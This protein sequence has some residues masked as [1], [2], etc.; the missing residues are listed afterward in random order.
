M[1]TL[2]KTMKGWLGIALLV[3]SVSTAVSARQ[4]TQTV[5]GTVVDNTTKEPL[6]G[7]SVAL[8]PLAS[9]V[10]TSTNEWGEFEINDVPVG[11]QSIQITYTG[12]KSHIVRELLVVSGKQNVVH[13]ALEQSPLE[14]EE[15]KVSAA[16]DNQEF[17]QMSKVDITAEQFQRIAANYL[18]PA[19]V[20]MSSPSVANTNDQNNAV[21]VRGNSPIAN[22]WRLEGVEIVNP[23]HLANAGTISDRPT[24]NGGG[25][26]VL[27]TQMLDKSSFLMG[28]MPAGY[29]N[30]IGGI[31]DMN[32]RRGN[33]QQREYTAQASLIGLDFAAEGPFKKGG[34][35][36][37]LV[38]YRYSFTG[39]LALMGVDFGGETI[40]F[41]DLSFNVSLPETPIGKVTLFGVNG[42][43]SNVYRRRKGRATV[44]KELS[45]IDYASSIYAYGITQEA[46][47]GGKNSWRNVL[48]YSSTTTERDQITHELNDPS[49]TLSTKDNEQVAKL[50][51]ASSVMT[52]WGDRITSKAGVRGTTYQWGIDRFEWDSSNLTFNGIPQ[53]D[54]NLDI[55]S[56][57]LQPFVSGNF[58]IGSKVDLDLG[59]NSSWFGYTKEFLL[60]PRANLEVRMAPKTSF[61]FRSGIY[62]QVLSPYAYYTATS[63]PASGQPVTLS[64]RGNPGLRYVKSWSS[65][66]GW[67]QKIGNSSTLGATAFYQS[68]Y[69]LPN[70][71]DGYYDY[72]NYM[73]YDGTY[74]LD[75]LASGGRG[76]VYGVSVEH[77]QQIVNGFYIWWGGSMYRSEYQDLFG[78]YRA[79]NFDGRYSLNAT[80]GK[81]WM[82]TKKNGIERLFGVNSRMLYQGSFLQQGPDGIGGI[83]YANRLGD[84]FRVDMR[85]QWTRFKKGHTQMFAID[86]Q[87]LLNVDNPAYYYFDTVQNRQVLKYQLGMIPVLVYR[88]D[89]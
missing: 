35:A 28:Y 67:T 80:F 34:S 9:G 7:A 4:L 6:I 75:V 74:P 39:V 73:N 56:L 29:G 76:R 58:A 42:W 87:N 63:F 17:E 5:R 20:V 19:R 23:N 30:A 22:T 47:L 55:K 13:V 50:S 25:V 54:F 84:Y 21:S 53:P 14:L 44:D 72:F 45:D 61:S 69:D 86:I 46:T 43:N 52:R 78:K 66:I 11:R 2:N 85:V 38:N 18:D 79:S 70:S 15:V 51:F 71:Y 36:S 37:Y 83:F 68:L 32:L 33:N 89:F 1:K 24:Q 82:A 40:K 59:L 65:E 62:S 10:G 26:N 77:R 3:M 31:F 8:L 81:E 12:Y 64:D 57:L 48:V 60:E 27:S 41:Q 16:S 49:L 88:I